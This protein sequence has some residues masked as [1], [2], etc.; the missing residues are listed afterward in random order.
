[1][2]Q[3]WKIEYELTSNDFRNLHKCNKKWENM[4][5]T[6]KW[7]ENYQRIE[8]REMLR[9]S[10]KEIMPTCLAD[11]SMR[12]EPRYRE[13]F[14]SARLVRVIFMTYKVCCRWKYYSIAVDKNEE[15]AHVD[16]KSFF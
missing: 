16:H 4:E 10:R 5:L 1:M 8:K 15:D 2:N 3:N 14:C 13:D 12:N 9:T 7:N 6:S 11:V